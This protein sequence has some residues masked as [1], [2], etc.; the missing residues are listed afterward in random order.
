MAL[1]IKI[2]K[3]VERMNTEPGVNDATYKILKIE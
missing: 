1:Q 3:K 2:R